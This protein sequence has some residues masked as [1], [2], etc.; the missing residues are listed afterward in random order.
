MN[1]SAR[2]TDRVRGFTLIE[3]LV[4]I[5]IIGL[6]ISILLPSLQA[7][8]RTSRTLRCGTN[9]RQI[10]IGWTIYADENHGHVVPGRP[11]K[12][13]DPNRNVYW[14]GNGLHFRPR[15]YVQMGAEA[16]F[17][18]FQQPSPDPAQDNVKAVDGSD[19]FLCPEVPEWINNRNY[20]FGYNS[21]FLGNARFK[22]GAEANGFINFP[23]PIGRIRAAAGTVMAADAMGTA[24]G[25][26]KRARTAFRADGGSDL[27]AV[28]NHAWSLDPPRLTATSDYC[29]DGN[30]APEHRSAIHPRHGAKANAMYCDGHVGTETCATLGYQENDDGSIAANAEGAHNRMFS[31]TGQ[32]DDPPSIR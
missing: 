26:E 22:N 2:P 7:A 14:V 5:A 9:L 28:G 16:G 27:F 29:D 11:A 19:V 15:W 10:G 30:R 17:Y 6:L 23:V 12:F 1:L 25:K 8:R 3:L 20:A 21:Q 32:D 18:A 13:A 31:G 4:V 24:A